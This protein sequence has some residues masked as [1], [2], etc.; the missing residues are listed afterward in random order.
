MQRTILASLAAVA[1]LAASATADTILS[2]GF[3][4]L[5][6]GFNAATMSYTAVGVNTTTLQT[7]GNVNR[8]LDPVATAIYN[9]GTAAD[10]INVSLAVSGVAGNT[11][12]GDGSIFIEDAD[13]DRFVAT[14]S[15]E[16]SFMAPAVFFNGALSNISFVPGAGS[17]NTFDGPSG[18]SF[19]LTFAPAQP[20]F[21][22]AIVQLY[23]DTTGAFFNQSF[24]GRATQ[25]SGAVIPSPGALTLLGVGGL[26]A[27]RRRR[28]R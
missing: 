6:G 1:G 9:P 2:F 10:R 28:S 3:T 17:N 8:H 21:T 19:P 11:A 13:G 18:G 25:V 12:N 16:F 26:L 22:G 14:V 4:D 7:A 20:P 5:A 15:G 27:A 24:Q 23:F